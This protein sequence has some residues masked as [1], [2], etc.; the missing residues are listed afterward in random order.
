MINLQLAGYSEK[1]IKE[2]ADFS[3]R[4]RSNLGLGLV[5]PGPSQGNGNGSSSSTIRGYSY[6]PAQSME[7]LE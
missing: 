1:D 7:A 5:S 4:S 2:L 3:R 6:T